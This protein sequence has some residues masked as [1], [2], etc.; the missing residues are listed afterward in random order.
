MLPDERLVDD[1]QQTDRRQVLHNPG[2]F[3]FCKAERG[4]RKRYGAPRPREPG[5]ARFLN[6]R[7]HRPCADVLE[8]D[9]R[10]NVGGRES[11][12]HLVQRE[13]PGNA[14]LRVTIV[15][16]SSVLELLD[17]IGLGARCHL[18]SDERVCQSVESVESLPLTSGGR[19]TPCKRARRVQTTVLSIDGCH[20]QLDPCPSD[21]VPR[22]APRV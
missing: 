10:H 12:G 8:S 1:V 16:R 11:R 19:P 20:H 9:G 3:A 6:G 15:R 7:E 18:P 21:L 17:P 4:A 2:V 13:R 22:D 14:Q 5:Q